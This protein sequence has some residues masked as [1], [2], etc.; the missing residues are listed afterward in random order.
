VFDPRIREVLGAQR[1]LVLPR[2]A[3]RIADTEVIANRLR[4]GKQLASAVD[5]SE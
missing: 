4:T 5:L 1:D 2:R 3:E